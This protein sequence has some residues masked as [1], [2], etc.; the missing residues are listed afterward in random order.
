MTSEPGAEPAAPG[1]EPSGLRGGVRRRRR[2]R[3][4]RRANRRHRLRGEPS[5]DERTRPG[6]V[7]SPRP[8]PRAGDDLTYPSITSNVARSSAAA[9][10]AIFSASAST[11]A[12]S[13]DTAVVETAAAA[14]AAAAASAGF[15]VSRRFRS[16]LRRGEPD[17]GDD[18]A[19]DA[20][21]GLGTTNEAA[22]TFASAATSTPRSELASDRSRL[23]PRAAPAP[24]ESAS[25]RRRLCLAPG[26]GAPPAATPAVANAARAGGARALVRALDRPR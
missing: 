25:D 23:C 5:G 18:A 11:V 22:A 21:T 24:V 9:S 19:G 12:A 16:N 1:E 6:S 20:R 7:R 4:L 15:D 2:R 17:G 8:P 14:A 26:G 3:R 10:A 13:R